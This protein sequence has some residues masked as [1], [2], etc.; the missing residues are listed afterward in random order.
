MARR[1]I[2]SEVATQLFLLYCCSYTQNYDLVLNL[3][4]ILDQVRIRDAHQPEFQQVVDEVA[5][6][7]RPVFM[8]HP[9]LLPIFERILEPENV[10]TFR[11]PWIDDKG[12][13]ARS[14]LSLSESKPYSILRELYLVQETPR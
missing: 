1:D 2:L 3:Q 14:C 5:E 4:Q 13:L 12:L 11:V 10:V 9:K 7:L 6:S 8:K